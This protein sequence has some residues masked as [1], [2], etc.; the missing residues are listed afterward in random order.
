MGGGCQEDKGPLLTAQEKGKNYIFILQL[1]AQLRI[2]W[3]LLLSQCVGLHV[4]V[5]LQVLMVINSF[6]LKLHLP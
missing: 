6:F 2:W 4:H 3:G 5:T 1:C